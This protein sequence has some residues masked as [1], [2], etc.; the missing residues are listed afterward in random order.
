MSMNVNSQSIINVNILIRPN[1][2]DWLKNLR[3]VLKRERLA[4]VLVEPL[5][6]SPTVDAPESVQRAY[7]NCLVDSARAG[8]IIYTS[9]SPEFQKHYK[10]M[11]AYSIVRHLREHYNKQARTE[12]FK[13]SE[14]LFGSKMEK[15]TF[16]ACTE[17][18][19]T[20]RG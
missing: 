2:L 9:M 18:V 5:P 8:L 7:R 20:L 13:V 19:N 12:R 16:S 14:L 4:Y 11:D 1:F 3:I 10:T 15:G 17:D 6:Q